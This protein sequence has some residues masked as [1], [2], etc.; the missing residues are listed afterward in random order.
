MVPTTTTHD[1]READITGDLY[2][3]E[4]VEVTCYFDGETSPQVSAYGRRLTKAG[5]IDRRETTYSLVSMDTVD[6]ER[7]IEYAIA[8]MK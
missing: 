5:K 2:A 1:C 3:V 6:D 7:F 4:K 8:V